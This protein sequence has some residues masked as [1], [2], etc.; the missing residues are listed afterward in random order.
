ML[1]SHS[2]STRS[3]SELDDARFL[4]QFEQLTLDKRLFNHHGHLRIA[5][6]YLEQY[7][8]EQASIKTCQGISA[9]AQALGAS[10]KFHWT[11]TDAMVRIIHARRRQ[12]YQSFEDFLAQHQDLVMSAE[13]VL[14][15]YFTP[16]QLAHPDSRMKRIKPEKQDF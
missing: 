15:T 4:A 11:I 3:L 10:T 1:V 5:W 8:L 6:L 9:Y 12:P 16:A 14:L 2:P 13:Q 7:P